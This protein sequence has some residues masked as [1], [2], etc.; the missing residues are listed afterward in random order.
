MQPYFCLRWITPSISLS[1]FPMLIRPL[2]TNVY[3]IVSLLPNVAKVLPHR[4]LAPCKCQSNCMHYV[5]N[6]SHV[7]AYLIVST[8]VWRFGLGSLYA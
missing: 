2:E 8:L 1:Q 7:S 6:I 4:L 5:Y 3:Y